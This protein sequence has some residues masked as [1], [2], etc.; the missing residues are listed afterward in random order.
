MYTKYFKSWRIS[1]YNFEQTFLH[2]YF[3]GFKNQRTT[4]SQIYHSFSF[5]LS[6]RKSKLARDTEC[7]TMYLSLFKNWQIGNLLVSAVVIERQTS[8]CAFKC[9]MRIRFNTL[10]NF[11]ISV[12]YSFFTT[13]VFRRYKALW[14]T[15]TIVGFNNMHFTIIS[16][17]WTCFIV[18][19]HCSR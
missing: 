13:T 12:A 4:N 19:A 17:R 10:F 3:I 6:L 16:I 14:Q 8:D 2:V 18:R 15:N 9:F 5:S 11:H 7:I 1:S